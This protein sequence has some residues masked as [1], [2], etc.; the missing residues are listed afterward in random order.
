METF[1]IYGKHA[2]TDALSLRPD[3]IQK[4]F[5]RDTLDIP[6]AFAHSTVP[7]SKEIEKKIGEHTA[8]QY[9]AASISVDS[10]LIDF[11]DWAKKHV[12]AA[13]GILVL[14][15]LSDPHNVGAV[16]RSAAALGIDAVLIPEHR[17]APL[18]GTVAKT[19]AGGIFRVPLVSTP[20][21]NDALR[22]LRD[23]GFWIYGLDMH[24]DTS[25]RSETFSRPSVFVIGN[26]E[27]G[28]RE[29]TREICDTILTIPMH[30]TTESLNASVSAAIT[31]YEWRSQEDM[32]G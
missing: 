11:K 12:D 6:T 24:G 8:H 14:G 15:E 28:I 30:G 18:T 3:T 22:A 27:R 20:N 16:I 23:K 32:R 21:I 19:S 2:V 13:R 29:K 26:E 31:L 4:I 17:Q 9:I 10:L 5:A 7:F 25:L 1:L